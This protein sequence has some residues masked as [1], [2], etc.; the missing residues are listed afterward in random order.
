MPLDLS[1]YMCLVE[2]PGR[3]RKPPVFEED[4][5]TSTLCTQT[6]WIGSVAGGNRVG[7]R[8]TLARPRR[9][10]DAL[11]GSQSRR[12]AKDSDRNCTAQSRDA[13]P[14]RGGASWASLA[15][16][17]GSTRWA[18]LTP[19]P[20]RLW[21]VVL[22]PIAK[23]T[24]TMQATSPGPWPRTDARSQAP[25][26]LRKTRKSWRP[27]DCQHGLALL[28]PESTDRQTQGPDPAV[29]PRLCCRHVPLCVALS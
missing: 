8:H 15:F 1:A 29:G 21:E 7:R 13:F 28:A 18:G 6:C 14:R 12:R 26:A 9:Q 24:S 19:P 17:A 2:D 16:V 23:S 3:T 22:H 5:S 4:T 10:P 27:G 11:R 20:P 25:Q